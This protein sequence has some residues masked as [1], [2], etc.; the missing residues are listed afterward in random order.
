MRKIKGDES[1]RLAPGLHRIG[2]DVVN[3]YLVE[4]AARVTIVDA[5]RP[6]LW[7]EL[8]EELTR[9]SLAGCSVAMSSRGWRSSTGRDRSIPYGS[10]SSAGRTL[11]PV[12][13]AMTAPAVAAVLERVCAV[14]PTA[15]VKVGIEAAG[16]YHRPLLGSSV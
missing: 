1:M 9:C 13:F 8:Q 7:R 14:L 6:G 12:D 10:K 16:Y 5:G 3:A 2:S 11:G 4:D 15:A